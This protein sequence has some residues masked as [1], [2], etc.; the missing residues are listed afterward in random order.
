MKSLLLFFLLIPGL[1]GLAQKDSGNPNYGHFRFENEERKV[2][3]VN[4]FNID[5]TIQ[6]D[7]FKKEL[8][9]K[10]IIS[11]M[12]ENPSEVSGDL[13]KAKID[14]VKYG[15]S[16]FNAPIYLRSELTANVFLE[17]KKGRY[18]VTLSN[19]RF[20]NNGDSDIIL[21]SI[22][23]YAPTSKGNEESI[24][25]AFSFREDGTVRTRIKTMFEIIDKYFLDIF[26]YK[27]SIKL[28][29]DF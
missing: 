8:I 23:E 15:I 10:R 6:W 20:I 22:S 3:W 7:A 24:D 28:K 16:N 18:R 17:F 21:K 19:I 26:Q 4:V 12:N 2:S 27:Q 14:V 9:D 29:E 13:I 1:N 5:S 25:G 11:I